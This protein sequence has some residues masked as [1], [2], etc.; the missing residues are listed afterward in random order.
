M[1][2]PAK[3][4]NGWTAGEPRGQR[5]R[6]ALSRRLNPSDLLASL[7]SHQQHTLYLT[8]GRRNPII[9]WHLHENS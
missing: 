6:R 7:D 5:S 9:P 4:E 3:A 8:L 2:V 1:T